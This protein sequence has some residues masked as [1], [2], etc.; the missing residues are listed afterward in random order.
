M[1]SK[2]NKHYILLRLIIHHK[3]YTRHLF[4]IVSKNS[5]TDDVKGEKSYKSELFIKELIIIIPIFSLFPLQPSFYQCLGAHKKAYY[6]MVPD[7]LWYLMLHVQDALFFSATM[8]GG[9]HFQDHFY[10]Q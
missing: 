3:H 8:D 2:I 6:E 10:S 9:L 1:T 5:L 4:Q 7:G